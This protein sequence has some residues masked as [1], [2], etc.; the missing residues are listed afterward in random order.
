MA[1]EPKFYE[2][3][4]AENDAYGRAR[5]NIARLAGN[6]HA[7]AHVPFCFGVFPSIEREKAQISQT[8]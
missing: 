3:L 1:T 4:H 5:Y 2:R 8:E 6:F 7:F